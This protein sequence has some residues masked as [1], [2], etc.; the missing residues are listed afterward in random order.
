MTRVNVGIKP[1]QLIDEM[2]LAEHREIKRMCSY[3]IEVNRKH[4]QPIIPEQFTLGSGHMKFF[5]DKGK[6]TE[7]R[8]LELKDECERRGFTVT[9]FSQNWNVYLNTG[10]YNCYSPREEDIILIHDR[11]N[12]RLCQ[13]WSRFMNNDYFGKYPFHYYGKE[14]SFV[15]ALYLIK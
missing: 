9:D 8:Y 3:F 2:L 12:V 14:I 7:E 1:E 11:I 10:Y 13:M 6:Y 15:D 4:V 5:L